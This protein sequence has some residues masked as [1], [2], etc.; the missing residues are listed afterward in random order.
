M[1][2][3]N[4]AIC[5]AKTQKSFSDNE[6]LRGRP[7]GFRINVREVEISAGA[8]FII[9]ILGDMMRMPGLPEIPASEGM[10]IDSNGVISG[11]S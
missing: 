7:K 3:D 2:F 8:Q 5:M 11:L 9:P 6:L 4:F 1:G 10:T